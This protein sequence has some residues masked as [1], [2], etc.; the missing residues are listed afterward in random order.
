MESAMQDALPEVP[1]KQKCRRPK[2]RLKHL[3]K[4]RSPQFTLVWRKE[5]RLHDTVAQPPGMDKTTIKVNRL[6]GCNVHSLKLGELRG[7]SV[8]VLITVSRKGLW[9]VVLEAPCTNGTSV[10][11]EDGFMHVHAVQQL[12]DLPTTVISFRR[13]A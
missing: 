4:A 1:A 12:A 5:H 11:V 2:I 7:D 13:R 6:L 10:A 9:P 3:I 8:A